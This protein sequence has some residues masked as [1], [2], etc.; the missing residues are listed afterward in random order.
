MTQVTLYNET[1]KI[2]K[3]ER[4]SRGKRLHLYE[5]EQV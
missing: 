4:T 3:G 2:L 1:D 5:A